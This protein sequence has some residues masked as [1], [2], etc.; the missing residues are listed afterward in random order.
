MVSR[1]MPPA[2]SAPS[3][4]ST[5][6]PSGSDDDSAST[7]SSVSPMRVAGCGRPRALGLLTPLR[8]LAELVQPHLEA[9][10]QRFQ[11]PAVEHRLGGRLARARCVGQGHAARVVHQYGHH[12][13]LRPQRGDAQSR[14]P[15]QKKDQRHQTRFEQP[16]NHRPHPAQH[17]VMA[18]HMPE[19]QPRGRE[20]GERQQ[21]QRPGRQEDEMALMKNA[22]RVFKQDLEHEVQIMIWTCSSQ[23]GV[24]ESPRLSHEAL[25]CE[26]GYHG[27][28]GR[29]R[30]CP[31]PTSC[32]T[33]SGFAGRGS[34][35]SRTFRS[36][37][38]ITS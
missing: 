9:L 34:T 19:K 14:V 36:P 20:D 31:A 23:P 15:Q 28:T 21:P 29:G 26:T 27:Y 38:L 22:G 4:S 25:V 35:T 37:F 13:L 18:S 11:Q 24:T 17:P 1:P 33:L 6:A 16:D 12:V 7:R 10:A 2:L 30:A 8:L 3:L 5:M 32:K